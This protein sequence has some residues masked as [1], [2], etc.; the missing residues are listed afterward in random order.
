MDDDSA[1]R[2]ALSMLLEQ[3][4][5]QVAVFD[6]AE[7]FLDIAG[8]DSRGCAIVDLHMA[9]MDGLELQ[10]EMARRGLALAVIVLTG[11]GD[12][13]ASVKAIKGGA[14]DF[15]TKPVE[16]EQLID[17]VRAAIT[18]GDTVRAKAIAARSAAERLA[19]LTAR[20][21]DVMALTIEGLPNKEIARVLG[22][23]H[24]TVE[25]HRA[26]IMH[27]TGAS[28]V[29]ELSRIAAHEAQR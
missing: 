25:I 10:A 15:L 5:F 7:A 8:S 9:G 13:P 18:T 20:E 14:V 28:N 3:H 4:G 16:A 11:H 6:S 17:S 22:I 19:S 2:D 12:I 23:S 21:R 29:F 27:K 26:R 1:V 24:R